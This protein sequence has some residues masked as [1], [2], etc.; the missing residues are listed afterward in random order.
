M[1]FARDDI[2]K[3]ALL[4]VM[5]ILGISIGFIAYHDQAHTQAQNWAILE[6]EKYCSQQNIPLSFNL[7]YQLQDDALWKK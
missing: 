5:L 6:V 1:T 3:V 7:T 2:S 4:I